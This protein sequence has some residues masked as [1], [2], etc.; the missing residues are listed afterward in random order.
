MNI[1]KTFRGELEYLDE[2]ITK[3]KFTTSVLVITGNY[4]E[5]TSFDIQTLFINIPLVRKSLSTVRL[6]PLY[7]VRRPHPVVKEQLRSLPS[8]V[9]NN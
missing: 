9:R 2:D 6:P 4:R 3:L 7:I 1:K 8:D 5:K